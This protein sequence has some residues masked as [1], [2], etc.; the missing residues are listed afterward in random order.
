MVNKHKTDMVAISE[1]LVNSNKIEGYK[2]FLGFNHCISNINGKI[3]CFW[4]D[5]CDVSVIH[6]HVQQMT[7]KVQKNHNCQELFV[8]A[9]YAKCTA[10]ERMDL[11]SSLENLNRIINQPWC[12]GGDFNVIL[13]PEEKI[14]GLPHRNAESYDFFECMDSCGMMDIGYIG[15]NYTWC[16][17]WTPSLR[18]WKRLDRVFVNDQW[19]QK[20]NSNTV[21]HL[22]RVGSD[23]RPLL[24][25]NF[26]EIVTSDWRLHIQG[27]PMWKLQQKLKRLGKKLSKWSREGI[28]DVHENTEMWEDRMQFLEDKD[29]ELRTDDSRED[30]NK[31]HAEYIYWLNKQDSILKQKSQVRWF[32]E[33][34]H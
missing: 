2:R 4:R 15:S 8:T 31:G 12:I 3:W 34:Q 6:N 24:F 5:G 16:N 32:E 7:L 26:R 14:G 29:M 11:W 23:H 19:A 27:N 10:S 30:L 9:V 33:E 17:N 18:I 13:H 25:K 28:C 21:K 1:P 20:Y 22:P